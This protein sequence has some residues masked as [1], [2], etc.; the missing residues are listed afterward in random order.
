[1][2]KYSHEENVVVATTTFKMQMQQVTEKVAEEQFQD[3][4]GAE[5]IYEEESYEDEEEIQIK[6]VVQAPP[7]MEDNK[8]QVHDPIEEVNLGTW[9]S[10]RLLTLVLSYPLT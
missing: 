7:K 5:V 2:T 8:P 3:I 4:C 6:D 9:K 10:Q 1:M